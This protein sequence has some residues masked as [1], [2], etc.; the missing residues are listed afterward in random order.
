MQR[1]GVAVE[2]VGMPTFFGGGGVARREEE[3][4]TTEGTEGRREKEV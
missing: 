3:G 4:I 2:N 1:R